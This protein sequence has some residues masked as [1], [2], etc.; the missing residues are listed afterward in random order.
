M[1]QVS[2]RDF[3]K[4]GSLAAAGISM[5]TDKIFP[6]NDQGR[7]VKVGVIGTGNRGT[8]HVSNL[9]TIEGVEIVSGV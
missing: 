4:T 1:K 6:G 7:T 5:A 2:R 8:S 9:L 3:I